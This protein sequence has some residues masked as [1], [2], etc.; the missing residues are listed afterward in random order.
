MSRPGKVRRS[1]ARRTGVDRS[2][3]T[4]GATEWA[5]GFGNQPQPLF[6]LYCAYRQAAA[7]FAARHDW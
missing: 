1:R 7:A 6:E 5:G 4:A 3:L 2:E